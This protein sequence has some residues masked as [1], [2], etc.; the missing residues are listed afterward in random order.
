MKPCGNS[1]VSALKRIRQ[2]QYRRGTVEEKNGVYHKKAEDVYCEFS[3]GQ[4]FS[5]APEKSLPRIYL[6]K[7][8]CLRYIVLP[9]LS[10]MSG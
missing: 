6:A 5:F 8:V 9:S 7:T 2:T 10:D 3:M 4:P 1:L